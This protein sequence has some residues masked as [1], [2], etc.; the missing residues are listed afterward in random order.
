M[1]AS[2]FSAVA[3]LAVPA[4]TLAA[5]GDLGTFETMAKS[6]AS[7]VETLIPVAASLAV[8]FFFWNLAMFILSGSG[9]DK[10]KSKMGMVWGVVAIF[11]IFSIWG[12]V[13]FLR[14]TFGIKDNAS[15]A[16]PRITI[17][18]PSASI[19]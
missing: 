14:D 15:Q 1:K 16:V 11:I 7:I 8:L 2:L 6:V 3:F 18:T 12:L 9:E 5:A 10:A 19:S 17:T 13:G 4:V